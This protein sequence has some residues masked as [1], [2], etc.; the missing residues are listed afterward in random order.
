MKVLIVGAGGQV[1]RALT[2]CVPPSFEVHAAARAELNVADVKA[3]DSSVLEFAPDVI[4]NAAAYT[5]VDRAESEMQRAQEA[6]VDGP[7]N[8]A[9]AAQRFGSRLLHISSDFVFDGTASRP[10]KP[11]AVTNPI[12]VYGRTKRDGELAV[13]ET[14]GQRAAILRTSWVYAPTGSSFVHT[15]LRLMS[16]NGPV[17]VIDDQIGTPTTAHSVASVLWRLASRA[18]LGGVYHWSDAGVASWYDFA[19]AIQEEAQSSGLLGS[20]V[21]VVPIATEE[22]PT[23]ARRPHYS[24]LDKTLTSQA[25]GVVPV[26]WRINLRGVIGELSRA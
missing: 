22:Y 23:A 17:R 10:Y 24:V 13:L 18:D 6:N 26:H 9:T 7:L 11:D 5:A 12:S 15:M 25:L 1:G 3:V 21:R 4:I 14:L 20:D 16:A 8:L 2:D 19:V